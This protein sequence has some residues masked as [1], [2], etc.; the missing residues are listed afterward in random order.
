MFRGLSRIYKGIDVITDIAS[1][2]KVY[3]LS[4]SNQN[5]F[6][7]VFFSNTLNKKRK[8]KMRNEFKVNYFLSLMVVQIKI[9][10]CNVFWGLETEVKN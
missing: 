1:K 8:F 6:V 2:S 5:I 10:V 7:S 9:Y 3:E 4:F